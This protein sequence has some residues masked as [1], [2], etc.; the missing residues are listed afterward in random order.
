MNE[1]EVYRLIGSVDINP[2]LAV[3]DRLPFFLANPNGD[4][5]DPK[6]MPCRVV[7]QAKFPAEVTALIESLGLGGRL[8]R[9]LIRQLDPHQG[10]PPHVDEWMPQ[11]MQWRRFQ[12]PLKSHPDIV[13][14]W[15]DDDVSVHLAPGNLYEVRFDRK[16]EVVNNTDVARSHLQIDQIDAVI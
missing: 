16:H 11:E 3:W 2:V 8:G 4:R 6:K 13:M 9:A 15:P 14:R 12:V 5:A 10:I 1:N 7:L